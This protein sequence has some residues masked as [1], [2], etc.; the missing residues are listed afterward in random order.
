MEFCIK[1]LNLQTLFLIIFYTKKAE[2]KDS[3]YLVDYGLSQKYIDNNKN[4]YQYLIN[5]KFVGTIRYASRHT[6]NTERYSRR[7]DLESLIY[8]LVYLYK[9]ELPWQN[10][11]DLFKDMP[12]V[13]QFI[14]KNI[15]ALEF[16]EE[17]PYEF[18]VILFEKEKQK[19]KKEA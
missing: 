4:H 15:C 13:F 19:I 7:D 12:K 10:P 9:G 2:G 8:V 14:Y 16:E 3:L 6:L 5:K 17:S 11:N 18:F 1:T